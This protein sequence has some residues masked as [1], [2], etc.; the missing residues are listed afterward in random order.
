MHHRIP[1]HVIVTFDDQDK[2]PSLGQPRLILSAPAPPRLHPRTRRAE[3]GRDRRVM[4]AQRI[5]QRL[6][7]IEIVPRQ[8]TNHEV[9]AHGCEDPLC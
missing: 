3:L 8:T 6:N 9:M 7:E 5:P 2:G 1:N 4:L